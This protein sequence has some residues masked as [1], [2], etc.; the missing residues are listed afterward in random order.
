MLI[1][2]ECII[3]II[4]TA[5]CTRVLMKDEKEEGS[6]VKQTTRQSNTAHRCTCTAVHL[7]LTNPTELH[8]YMYIALP[9]L[10]DF[11]YFFLPSVSSLIK[12]YTNAAVLVIWIRIP[13]KAVPL[14]T[15]TLSPLNILPC[16]S[17]YFY[18]HVNATVHVYV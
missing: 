9:C 15:F 11:A 14:L 2:D 17:F 3:M 1:V 8:W 7:E 16:L 18:V 5:T 4:T 12:T 6:K 13:S 10:F